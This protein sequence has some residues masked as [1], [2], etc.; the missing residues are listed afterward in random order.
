MTL[1]K[2]LKRII[3]RTQGPV[4]LAGHAYAGA[5]IGAVN[6]KRVK[7]LVYIAALAP[8][9]GETVARLFAKMK[10]TQVALTRTRR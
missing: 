2:A 8:H 6:D 5:V 7:A 10:N 1:T 4:I 9:E 3:V